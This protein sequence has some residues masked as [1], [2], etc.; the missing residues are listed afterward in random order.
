[1]PR[2]DKDTISGSDMTKMVG[3]AQSKSF[4]RSES[5]LALTEVKKLSAAA[6]RK[7]E[8]PLLKETT[9]TLHII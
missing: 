3:T 4:K 7:H 9:P 6:E 5:N 2:I 1:M 8:R